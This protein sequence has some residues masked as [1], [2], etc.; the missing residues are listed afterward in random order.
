[1]F[2]EN[3]F[4]NRT[5]ELINNSKHQREG[6]GPT[7]MQEF[8][9]NNKTAVTRKIKTLFGINL[10]E[11]MKLRF[12]YPDSWAEKLPNSEMCSSKDIYSRVME[13]RGCNA[14]YLDVKSAICVEFNLTEMEL[15]RRARSLFQCTLRELFQPTK[16]EAINALIRS[17]NSKEFRELLGVSTDP[18]IYQK[19]FGKSNYVNSKA[20]IINKIKV[21]DIIPNTSDNEAIVFSQVL[22]DGS[23]DST[24]KAIRITHSIAQLDYLK[25]K[26][27]L[28]K[29]AY[30][31][32]ASL[33][34]IKVAI[35]AQGHEYCSW[36]SRKLPE[37]IYLK[38][39]R[40]SYEDMVKSL[41]PLGWYLWYFD[42]G[43]L[44]S[45]STPSLGICAGIEKY[46]HDLI[47]EIMKTYNIDGN[48]FAK[49]YS[50]QKRVEIIKFLNTFVKP[51]NKI[52]PKCMEYKTQFMI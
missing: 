49:S 52:T 22:G 44:A 32:L 39:D 43:N 37:H 23:Y 5:I 13:L 25:L 12:S 20:K 45:G 36:Y 7:L 6:V 28:L 8:E 15:L 18:G 10:S 48:A 40:Y 38:L 30:P 1:M 33:S 17:N 42:D 31:E 34:D 14:S 47:Q 51:F 26:V 2:N 19:Y 27:S 16:E 24:R 35:H 41:T 4:K 21:S 9:L 3:E 50:I 46:K 11:M 29:N